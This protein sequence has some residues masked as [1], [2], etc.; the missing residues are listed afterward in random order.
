[1]QTR[2]NCAPCDGVERNRDR[3]SIH[4]VMSLSCSTFTLKNM[5]CVHHLDTVRLLYKHGLKINIFTFLV[6]AQADVCPGPAIRSLQIRGWEIIKFNLFDQEGPW[7]VSGWGKEN[8]RPPVESLVFL[9]QP[10][11]RSRILSFLFSKTEIRMPAQGY[12]GPSSPWLRFCWCSA[13]QR[14]SWQDCNFSTG[15]LP[16]GCASSALDSSA[17]SLSLSPFLFP[18]LCLLASGS[19]T[20]ILS[21][22]L[23]F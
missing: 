5:R 18:L 14:R 21:S 2:Q 10:R 17:L 8:T 13:T 9:M 1:M 22:R 15:Q 3:G 19:L 16:L 6:K 7:H 11:R 20:T 4:A 12:G 23:E